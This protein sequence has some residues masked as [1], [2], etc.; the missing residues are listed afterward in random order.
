MDTSTL[1]PLYSSTGP[2][3]TL[4]VDVSRDNENGAHE[5][6]LRVRAACE[7]LLAQG[8]EK[9]LVEAARERLEEVVDRPAPVARLVVTTPDGVV[10]DDLAPMRV[11]RTVAT[12]GALPDLASWIEHRDGA[13]TF[14]LAVVDHRGGDVAVLNSD[15]PEPEEHE[16]IGGETQYEHKV[17]VGGWSALRYQHTTE[18]VWA[19]HAEAVVEQVLHHVREGHRLVLLAGDPASRGMV[20]DGLDH[21]DID[22]VE[23]ETGTRAEDGGD[24]ALQQAIR[25]ALNGPRGGATDAGRA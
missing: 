11:D 5:H 22:L 23:L 3:A 19:E 10:Y 24:A 18:N 7:D 20:R 1:N 6:E 25:E 14:V 15:V 13:V 16:S 12:V 2:F 9:Q 21:P 4:I 17:P 8:A